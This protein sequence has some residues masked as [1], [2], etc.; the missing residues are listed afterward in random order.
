MKI[1]LS[2]VFVR[3]NTGILIKDFDPFA[4][5]LLRKVKIKNSNFDNIM[6]T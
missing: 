3:L 1:K 2:V 4:L 6:V 5:T